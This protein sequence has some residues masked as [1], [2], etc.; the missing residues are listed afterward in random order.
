MK[1]VTYNM[2]HDKRGKRNWSSV[3]D[4]FDPDVVVA[5]ERQAPF[6]CGIFVPA[7]WSSRLKSCEVLSGPEWDGMSDHNPVVADFQPDER[8]GTG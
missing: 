5:Q 8:S 1:I 3:L 6:H 4:K 7:S 2:L